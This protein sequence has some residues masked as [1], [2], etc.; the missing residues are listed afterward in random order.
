MEEFSGFIA[1]PAH[2]FAIGQTLETALQRLRNRYGGYGFRSWKEL[3]IPGHFIANEVLAGISETNFFAADITVPNFNVT[4]E[5]GFAIGRGNPIFLFK[6]RAIGGH[7]ELVRELGI[8]DTLG[9]AEYENSEEV[10]ARLRDARS[11]RAIPISSPLNQR[12]PVYLTD[13]KFKT[14]QSRQ[15]VSRIKKARLFFR[16]FD[17]QE[18]PRLSANTAITDVASSY[19]VLCQLVPMA[20]RDSNVHNLR[21]AF[22]AGLAAGMG[23]VTLLLQAGNDPVPLDYRDLVASYDDSKQ[24]EDYIAEFASRVAEAL[25]GESKAHS[26]SPTT[27]LETIDLGASSAEN[28]LRTLGDY[29]LRTDAY[30]RVLR[31]E[32]RLVVGRKGSGKTAIFFRVRDS[33]EQK[34]RAVV[35]DLKPDGYKLVKFRDSISGLLDGGSFEHTATALWE[36]VLLLE[37]AH[38]LLQDDR[39]RHVR[40][41]TIFEPYRTLEAIFRKGDRLPQGDFAER[42]SHLLDRVAQRCQEQY[43]NRT[44]ARLEDPQVTGL[45]YTQNIHALQDAVQGY[46]SHKE[47][48]WL[49]FDNLDKGWPT[50]GLTANDL[51]LART[52]LDATRKLERQFDSEKLNVHTVVF[53]RS[54]VVELLVNET[55]D[56]GK[57]AK[58]VVDWSDPDMLREMIRLRLVHSGLNGSKRFDDLWREIC[59]SHIEVNDSSQYLIDRSLM[60]PRYLIN[61]IDYCKSSAVNLRNERITSSDIEKGLAAFSADLVTDINYEIRD[62]N[63]ETPDLLHAFIRA[64]AS[65]PRIALEKVLAAHGVSQTRL[66]EVIDLLLWYGFLGVAVD[67]AEPRYI[68]GINYS[69][70]LL[71]ALEGNGDLGSHW[72]TVNPA[73][74]PA[75]QIRPSDD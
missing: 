38:K 33:V 56:R 63:P 17:P 3:D 66:Q 41:H 4:Y 30:T 52:L 24:I 74:H 26:L 5:T 15:I 37:I 21:V 11:H 60:R 68:Y 12:A 29:Y 42:L 16:S 43:G 8:Y 67:G 20:T 18:Q 49:L 7:D 46:L 57:E 14:D 13:T 31:G 27:K 61:L 72:Y 48:L 50:K 9:Y 22:I 47:H 2:P 65:M 71:K 73:F 51:T 6:N 25:Q 59:V 35:L 53:L 28:E 40:D 54:D 1:Y 32:A 34:P 64:D 75:L 58:V 36:Y 69:F 55:P 39:Q 45:L 70:P 10:L 23:K 62:V 19:G 44:N